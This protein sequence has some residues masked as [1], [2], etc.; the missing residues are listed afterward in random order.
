MF[1]SIF[2]ILFISAHAYAAEE[3]H[4]TGAGTYFFTT[5]QTV[6][7]VEY[8][9]MGM[10]EPGCTD[11][12]DQFGCNGPTSGSSCQPTTSMPTPTNIRD[13]VTD[14]E[15]EILPPPAGM[16]LDE[17]FLVSSHLRFKGTK[18]FAFI[19]TTRNLPDVMSR[20]V[21]HKRVKITLE[22]YKLKTVLDAV[23]LK[24]QIS[25]RKG[26]LTYETFG[27]GSLE[28]SASLHLRKSW[29]AFRGNVEFSFSESD[30]AP[31]RTSVVTEQGIRHTVNLNQASRRPLPKGKYTLS[32]SHSF[33]LDNIIVEDEFKSKLKSS[34][35][36]TVR[37]R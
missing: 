21:L 34:L 16:E 5:T 6:F 30:L 19:K 13:M 18:K 27:A 7:D 15:L 33:K 32:F 25:I 31:H 35:W 22:P 1:K 10:P 26:I 12:C 36:Y 11:V 4:V 29:N 14:V 8:Q 9:R 23:T 2:F 24:P 3:I 37:A 17:F 28:T 20:G